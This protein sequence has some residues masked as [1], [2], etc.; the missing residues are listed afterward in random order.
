MGTEQGDKQAVIGCQAAD[1]KPKVNVKLLDPSMSIS[2]SPS[3]SL[4]LPAIL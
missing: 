1:K 3:L 2:L 4:P